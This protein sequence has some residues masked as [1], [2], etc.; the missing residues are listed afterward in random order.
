MESDQ[1][2]LGGLKN[3]EKR[4]FLKAKALTFFEEMSVLKILILR[5]LSLLPT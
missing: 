3:Q 4:L 1:N 2:W 5:Y